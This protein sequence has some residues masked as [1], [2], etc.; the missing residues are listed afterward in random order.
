MSI[1]KMKHIRLFGMSGDREALLRGLQHLGCV[2]V[3]ES[4]G[5]RDGPAWAAFARVDDTALADTKARAE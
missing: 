4:A 5:E 1:V 3:Q 2:E